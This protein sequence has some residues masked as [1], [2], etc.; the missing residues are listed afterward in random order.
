MDIDGYLGNLWEKALKQKNPLL[1]NQTYEYIE[2][3][4]KLIEVAQIMK[5]EFYI[6]VPFD[7]VQNTSVRDNSLLGPFKDFYNSVFDNGVSTLKLKS[8]IRNFSKLKKGLSTRSNA[9][10]TGLENIWI[11]AEA[12]EKWELVKFLTEYYNPSLHNYK[13]INED[14][15]SYN[16]VK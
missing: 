6:V 14:I 13:Q 11:R 10:K 2:Y 1:Q 9:V 7:A 8:Q 3:L 16:L 12:L 5:K 15:Q 4:K